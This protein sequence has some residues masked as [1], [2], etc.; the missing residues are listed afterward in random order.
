MSR[1]ITPT[2]PVVDEERTGARKRC[3]PC[4]AGVNG[5]DGSER[6]ARACAMAVAW[7]EFATELEQLYKG[8][9]TIGAL[10]AKSDVDLTLA[11]LRGG[12]ERFTQRPQ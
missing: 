8:V 6:E 3:L 12:V 9:I 2:P 10:F 11:M 1:G 4:S 7:D 5:R